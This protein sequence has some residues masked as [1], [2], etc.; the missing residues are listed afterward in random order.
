[1]HKRLLFDNNISHRVIARIDSIFPESTHVMFEN[2]DEANDLD[3]W[4]FAK[5]NDLTIVTKDSDFND[6][7]ILY[8]APPKVIWIKIGN[9][10]V[11]DIVNFLHLRHEEIQSF[12]DDSKAL[13]LEI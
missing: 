2:L 6:L 5:A 9:C 3:V 8:G 10:R 12:L 7:A 11:D 1:M 13:I 4:R